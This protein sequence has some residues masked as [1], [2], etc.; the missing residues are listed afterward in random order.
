MNTQASKIPAVQKPVISVIMAAYN[1][2]SYIAAAV[3]SVIDQTFTDF[4]LIV[5]NDGSRDNTLGVLRSFTDRRIRIIDQENKGQ[6]AAFNEGFR[7]S[8]GSYIKFFDADDLLNPEML[9]RQL[10]V[11]ICNENTITYGEWARFYKDQPELADFSPLDY[12]KDAAPMDFLTARPEGVMLQC[13]SMLLPRHLV[14]I[15]GLWNE[16]LV[17]YNDTEFFTRI[18]L[19]SAG[20]KFTPGARLY[21]RSGTKSSVSVQT[22]RKYFESTFQATCLIGRHLL[23][24]ED[25]YRVRN[26]VS[27]MFLD[28]YY[29]MYPKYPDLGKKHLQ[30]AA[31]YG[32]AT[33]KPEGSTA[34]EAASTILGWKRARHLQFFYYQ[35]GLARVIAPVKRFLRTAFGKYRFARPNSQPST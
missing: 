28:R 4:E 20:V 19:A 25:S 17:L 3:K 30:K 29:A 9:Q 16:D 32:C 35:T 18:I 22:A 2:E 11:L 5:V 34:F 27:N 26:L 33:T 15:A 21:Y 24:H 10:D 12:W 23:A 14:E 1:A 31:E 7:A 6:D 13:G 8:L